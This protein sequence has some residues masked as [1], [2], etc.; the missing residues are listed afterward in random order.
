LALDKALKE[1]LAEAAQAL[2]QPSAV[3]GRL[4]AWL[5]ALSEGD[6]SE[7]RQAQHFADVR[8]V[9]RTGTADAD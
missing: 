3:A 4:D 6:V 1:A 7:E 5:T 8:D 9:L 2:G